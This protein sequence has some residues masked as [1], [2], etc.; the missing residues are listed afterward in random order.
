MILSRIQKYFVK[1]NLV[2]FTILQT[3]ICET[4]NA[5]VVSRIEGEGFHRLGIVKYC[6]Q[7]LHYLI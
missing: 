6:T 7:N 4:I 3:I 5:N 2:C 1:V